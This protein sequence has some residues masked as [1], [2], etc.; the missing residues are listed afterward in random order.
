MHSPHLSFSS[1]FPWPFCQVKNS[2]LI[3]Q[4]ITKH[5]LTGKRS[6]WS[7]WPN[8]F[9]KLT[10]LRRLP[11]RHSQSLRANNNTLPTWRSTQPRGCFH[12][13]PARLFPAILRNIY[14]CKSDE[15]TWPTWHLSVIPRPTSG[16]A[17][18]WPHLLQGR[19]QDFN[20]TKAKIQSFN[21]SSNHFL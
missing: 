10:N 13:F 21:R 8:L 12:V 16:G 19:H 14:Y 7:L 17:L 3:K 15:K 2:Y 6:I 11:W 1:Y 18:G 4:N 9:T 5:R 20:P